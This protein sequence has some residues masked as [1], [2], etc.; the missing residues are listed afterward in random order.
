VTFHLRAY[1]PGDFDQLYEI[2]QICYE[3]AIAY[4]RRELRN[5]MR[6]P[7]ATC[8]VAEIGGKITGFCLAA[9]QDEIGYIVTMDVLPSYRRLG[10]ASALLRDVE[11][12]LQD[13]DVQAIWL[14]TA[15]END[16]AIAFWQKN[17]FRKIRVR[18]RYYPGRR[19]AY[20]MTKLISPPSKISL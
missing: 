1:A 17:G 3:P 7:G 20:S 12:K 14:E 18:K 5:Y 13:N 15:T 2:D 6:F 9:W 16:P 11:Q 19:D 4:S 8:V 10:M